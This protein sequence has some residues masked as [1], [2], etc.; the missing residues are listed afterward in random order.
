M[1]HRRVKCTLIGQYDIVSKE[2]YI[3]PDTLYNDLCLLMVSSSLN[4]SHM[5]VTR[6]CRAWF[7][8]LSSSRISE[9]TTGYTFTLCMGYFASPG[10][11][12]R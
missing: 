2:R 11:D 12:T 9:S 10:K 6:F 5:F 3:S 8:E 7:S 1:M 4:G